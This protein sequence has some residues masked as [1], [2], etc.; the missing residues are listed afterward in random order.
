MKGRRKTVEN[1]A[2]RRKARR[3]DRAGTYGGQRVRER[4]RSRDGSVVGVVDVGTML[5]ET[6]FQHIALAIDGALTV[7][8]VTDGQLKTQ[9]STLAGGALLTP[10]GNTGDLRRRDAR[11]A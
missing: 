6:Y 5:T 11:N 10:E 3:R 4:P 2:A 8:V 1:G 9:A 7:Q